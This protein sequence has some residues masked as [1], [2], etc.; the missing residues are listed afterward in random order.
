M[1][2]DEKT[3]Y[4]DAFVTYHLPL[5]DFAFWGC[6][7]TNILELKVLS[8]VLFNCEHQESVAKTV[9]QLCR[10]GDEENIQHYYYCCYYYYLKTDHKDNL[11]KS[12]VNNT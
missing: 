5:L 1:L 2:H 10:L 9:T 6:L 12:A 8:Q 4:P 7:T 11:S 3:N